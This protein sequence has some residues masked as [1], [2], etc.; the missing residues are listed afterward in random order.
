VVILLVPLWTFM[1]S[2]RVNSY[3]YSSSFRNRGVHSF[4]HIYSYSSDLQL[5]P[6]GPW[7][8]EKV[9]GH[10]CVCVCMICE[11]TVKKIWQ[12]YNIIQKKTIQNVTHC[13]ISTLKII[14]WIFFDQV[15]Q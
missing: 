10:V 3:L 11:H 6:Q 4:I 9:R 8:M 15:I 14:L 7:D 13:L 2:S 1:T 5:V 12:S